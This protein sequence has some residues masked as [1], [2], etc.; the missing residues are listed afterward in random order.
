MSWLDQWDAVTDGPYWQAGGIALDGQ[1]TADEL[2]AILTFAY[3]R[4]DTGGDSCVC[5][6]S[7]F[8][9]SGKGEST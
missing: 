2:R 7:K 6:S 9:G 4:G 3:S 8:G 5:D 1:F